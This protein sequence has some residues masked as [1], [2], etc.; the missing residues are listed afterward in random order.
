MCYSSHKDFGQRIEKDVVREPEGRRETMPEER[1]EPHVVADRSRV[2]AF[3]HRE[4]KAR[5]SA[6]SHVRESEKV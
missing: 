5:K 4:P 1:R 3:L 6:V 2:W